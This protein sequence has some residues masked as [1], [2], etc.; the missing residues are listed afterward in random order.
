[1]SSGALL[2]W[3]FARKGRPLEVAVA[4]TLVVNDLALALRAMRDGVG[5]LQLPPDYVEDGIAAGE[6][7]S[8]LAD[9]MPARSDA[10]FLCYLSRRHIRA[11][12]QAFLDFLRQNMKVS[13]DRPRL[14][15]DHVRH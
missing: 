15:R 11:P 10:F 3:R 12:L 1:L 5:L 6:L 14:R 4:G 8:V 13:R 2:P 7:E 9:W